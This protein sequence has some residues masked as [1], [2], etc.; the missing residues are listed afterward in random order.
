MFLENIRIC[1]V[2]HVTMDR[3]LFLIKWIIVTLTG[4]LWPP[5]TKL[6]SSLKSTHNRTSDTQYEPTVQ[7]VE[8]FI[9]VSSNT[10]PVKYAFDIACIVAKS[11][12]TLSYVLGAICPV[13]EI[14]KT[15]ATRVCKIDRRF[16]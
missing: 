3:F 6:Q 2:L 4:D 8:W 7:Y 15:S 16:V 5:A 11:Y 10:I 1:T 14:L 9:N 12:T 13:K